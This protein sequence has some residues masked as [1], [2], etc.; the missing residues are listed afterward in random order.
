MPNCRPTNRAPLAP[1]FLIAV[2]ARVAAGQVPD[3]AHPVPGGSVS[4]VVRD[5]IAHTPLAGATVQLVGADSGTRFGRTV[6]S[7]GLGRYTLTNLPDGRYTI[8][9]FHPM[10]D[11]LGVDPP[12]RAVNIE[13]HQPVHLD[14]AS[15]SVGQVR[16]A[17]CGG[18]SGADSGAVVVG[19]V[20]DARDRAPAAG[21]SVTGEWLEMSFTKQGLVRRT[22]HLVATTGEN[23]WFALCNVPTAG[24]MALTATRGEDSTD[25]IELQIPAEGFL[26]RELY[27]G[28]SRTVVTPSEA[29]PGDTVARPPRRVRVGDGRL[30]GTV[31]RIA[32]GRPLASAR[33]SIVNG[34][35]TT[36]NERGEWILADAPTG[37]RMLDIRGVGYYPE[38]RP[39]DVVAGAAPVRSALFTL[40][41]MLDTVKVTAS[42]LRFDSDRSGFEARRRSGV[43]H[44][45]T[46]ADI[47][48]RGAIVTS[49]VFRS[50]PGVRLE[51]GPGFER[52]IT[53]NGPFGYCQPS[54]Y[55]DGF[56]FDN[57]S[58]STIDEWASPGRLSGIEVYS[59]ASVPPQYQTGMTGCGTILLWTKR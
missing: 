47:A 17:V 36:A 39:V 20:R 56:R 23:G 49:D 15:P 34:P 44:Y 12:L 11:S 51:I 14:L 13:G 28:P 43:G 18:P 30:T 59:E 8:G 29:P 40:S 35:Q 48:R 33:V 50:M 37:T 38:S 27:I 3:T 57:I 1:F 4:G 25:R 32:D 10:L 41:A 26:R 24:T 9:F 6:A 55:L 42:R 7:D 5:S 53:I 46:P 54:I 22:P 2:L 21:V 52:Q 58:A 31:V 16:S 45:L 19:V